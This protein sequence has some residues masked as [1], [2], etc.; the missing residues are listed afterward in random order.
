MCCCHLATVLISTLTLRY[1][2]QALQEEANLQAQLTAVGEQAAEER[3]AAEERVKEVQPRLQH[4]QH[5]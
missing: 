4:C 2:S 3:D 5:G 1:V